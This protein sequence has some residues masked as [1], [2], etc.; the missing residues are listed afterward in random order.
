MKLNTETLKETAVKLFDGQVT[1][2]KRDLWLA[3]TVCLLLGIVIG[4]V[5][6]P[7]T[8][9]VTIGSNNG[10]YSGNNKDCCFDA[11]ECECI[12]ECD[13]GE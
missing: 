2:Q 11:D 8:H 12:G 6:A 4:L 9:G 10:N 1:V 7:W 13:C 5:K 3:G